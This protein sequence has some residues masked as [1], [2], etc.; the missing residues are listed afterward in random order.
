MLRI[1]KC[2]KNP[3]MILY[4]L[5]HKNLYRM[6]DE[7]YVKIMYKEKFK[8]YPNLE[9]PKTFNEKLQ[10]LK[11]NDRKNEYTNLVD[12]YEAKKFVKGIIGEEYIIPTFGV[13]EKFDEIDFDK[14]P[15]Q[16]V[17]KATHYGDGQ[18][19]FFIKDKNKIDSNIGKKM[20]DILHKNLYDYTREWPYKNVKPRI[21]IEK[22]MKD[23]VHDNLMDYKLFCFNGIPK[24]ILVCSNR[25]GH[26]KNTNFYDTEWNLM[27]FTR[28]NHENNR[29]EIKKPKTLNEMLEI[30]KKVSKDIPFVRVDLYEI[31][32]RVYFGELTLYPSAGFEGFKPA[33]YDRILGE[34]I[35]LHKENKKENNEK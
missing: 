2:L 4:Y 32:G 18:G 25:N 21:L 24:I 10:W 12:K 19:I 33:K 16:F 22:Y 7:E 23:E 31:N 28:E 3:K 11:L 26:F 20:E 34:M 30:S 17:I 1:I 35:E 15:N 27:P 9:D 29:N 8:E 14:L 6:N 5:D 13:W